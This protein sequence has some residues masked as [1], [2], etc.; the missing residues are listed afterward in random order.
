LPHPAGTINHVLL[1]PHRSW[2]ERA[3]AG[4][5]R[6]LLSWSSGKDSAW[7]LQV[8]REQ[9]DVDVVGLL[10]TLTAV[11]DRV[12]MHAVRRALLEA[13]A[14]AVGL[15]LWTVPLPS[16]CSNREYEEAM[17]GVLARARAEGV[18]AVAFGDL[19]LAD[20]RRYREERL[21]GT[22]VHPL[23]PLW[24]RP[25]AA[26]AREMLAAGLR[27][28]LT[29]VDPTRVPAG[30]A[31]R[32]WD[33]DLLAELP[34][35]ADPCGENGEFHTFVSAGPMFDAPLV[36]HAGEVVERDGFVFADLMLA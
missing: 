10:C 13:Q 30:F 15:P 28:H 18:E 20:V 14:R 19:F 2:N 3:V 33:A 4:R 11:H 17:G 32:V 12:A 5:T 1:P 8:L 27:A 26:L 25:T 24:G 9:E 6:A 21:A 7:T 36:V 29:C 34:P 31:G 22:G 35:A 16:P 23:F